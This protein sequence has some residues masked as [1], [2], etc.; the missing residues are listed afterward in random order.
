MATA[1]ILIVEDEIIVG[2]DIQARLES[3]G[4]EILGVEPAAEEAVDKAGEMRPDLVLMDIQLQG[5][6]DGVEAAR[7]IR[8]R[9]DIPVI[10]LTA[11]ADEET[12]QRAKITEPH[13]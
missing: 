10:F 13:G 2:L 7:H 11:Y 3:L 4:Y 6:M 12:L 8:T 5:E 9:F 1:R